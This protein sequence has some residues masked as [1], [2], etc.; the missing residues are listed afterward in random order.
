MAE[1]LRFVTRDSSCYDN[2]PENCRKLGRLY[3]LDEAVAACPAG[4]RLP[5]DADWMQ[6][7]QAVGVPASE[8]ASERARGSGAGDRLKAGGDSGFEAVF[9]G[10]LSPHAG[11]G[12]RKKGQAAAYWTSTEAGSDDM[13]P[14]A[15][16]RD[17]DVR[18]SGIY[19]SKVNVT[20]K[21]S[22]RCVADARP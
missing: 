21:L 3:L 13:S 12:F 8:L 11:E 1:S 10:Y 2:D 5:T 7:E 17:V 14:L 19:R 20:Y 6:L 9:A 16:H 15:W 18:R 4:W 22:I